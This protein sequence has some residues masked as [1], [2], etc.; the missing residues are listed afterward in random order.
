[1]VDI[2]LYKFICEITDDEVELY[3]ELRLEEDL[4]V[5]GDDAVYFMEQYSKRFNVDISCFS[6]YEYF[7]PETDN[8]SLFIRKLFKNIKKDKTLTIADLRK[9]IIEKKL[10]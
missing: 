9:G 7:S 8:I 10:V 1:M 2:D 5:F 4:G 3:D 6:F